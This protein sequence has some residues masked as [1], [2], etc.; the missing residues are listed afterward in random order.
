VALR[1][2]ASAPAVTDVLPTDSKWFDLPAL[3]S[4]V[5]D[6]AARPD[7][8]IEQAAN[9]VDMNQPVSSA[10]LK[11][12]NSEFFAHSRSIGSVDQA[13][14][15]LGFDLVRGVLLAQ[16]FFAQARQRERNLPVD[17]LIHHGHYAGSLARRVARLEKLN[18]K[19]ADQALMAGAIQSAGM[20]V[21]SQHDP[22]RYKRVLTMVADQGHSFEQAESELFGC[23]HA[24]VGA[25]LLR[26]W[27]L[28]DNVV[29]AVAYQHNPGSCPHR[30]FSSLSAVY[31]ANALV[32]DLKYP[33]GATP[34]E[35][36]D[37]R[38]L[39]SVASAPAISEW[40]AN[41]GL[42]IQALD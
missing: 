25:R 16:L 15:L 24:A 12:L 41:A 9:L 23:D 30:N 14:Y 20:L 29:E 13:S 40:K 27:G 21:L 34:P 38:Y 5:I 10:L 33:D 39:L 42:P 28:P 35:T 31:A 32:Q 3:Y 1:E 4:Q 37:T 8:N 26:G 18:P 36:V 6:E 11:V 7:G 22:E 19:H 17:K 2:I